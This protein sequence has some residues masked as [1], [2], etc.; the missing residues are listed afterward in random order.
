M[1]NESDALTVRHDRCCRRGR[2]QPIGKLGPAKIFRN[3]RT[4]HG[5]QDVSFFINRAIFTPFC[6]LAGWLFYVHGRPEQLALR[7]SKL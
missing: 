2:E 7:L 1:I 3:R 5:K 4:V 6:F